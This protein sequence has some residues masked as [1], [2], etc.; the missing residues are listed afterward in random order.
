[1]TVWHAIGHADLNQ[2][3]AS[4]DTRSVPGDYTGCCPPH[5]CALRPIETANM[6]HTTKGDVPYGI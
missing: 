2:D 4:D 5:S 3:Q 6:K 1:M